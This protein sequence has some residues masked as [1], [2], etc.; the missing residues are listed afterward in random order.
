[1][2]FAAVE[3]VDGEVHLFKGLRGFRKDALCGVVINAV[4]VDPRPGKAP[5]LEPTCRA[6]IEAAT[7]SSGILA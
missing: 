4:E 1:M 3:L 5:K 6:C 2:F 7:A